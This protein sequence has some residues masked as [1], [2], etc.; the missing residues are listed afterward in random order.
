VYDF[1]HFE[2]KIHTRLTK[3][4]FIKKYSIN[5][6][7]AAQLVSGKR[8]QA[9]GWRLTPDGPRTYIFKNDLLGITESLTQLEFNK[10]YKGTV[11]QGQVSSLINGHKKLYKGWTAHPLYVSQN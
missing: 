2:K 1:Y 6:S 4:E 10:K 11:S 8:S 9:Q 5:S 3:L 7:L